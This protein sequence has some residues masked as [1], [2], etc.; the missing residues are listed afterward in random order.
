MSWRAALSWAPQT[1]FEAAKSSQRHQPRP[2]D[3]AC[4]SS[5]G[6]ILAFRMCGFFSGQDRQSI[7]SRDRYN[8][9]EICQNLPFGPLTVQS[10]GF[11]VQ[12]PGSAAGER[13]WKLFGSKATKACEN[14]WTLFRLKSF[15]FVFAN[16]T[17]WRC[18]KV[19]RFELDFVVD[20]SEAEQEEPWTCMLTSNTPQVH[21]SK[22]PCR[23]W[24]IWSL[25]MPVL[26]CGGGSHARQR[27]Q[28]SIKSRL[29]EAEKDLSL[30]TMKCEDIRRQW[31]TVPNWFAPGRRSVA[32]MS[33][34]DARRMQRTTCTLRVGALEAL[35]H[36]DNKT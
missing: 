7:R 28:R 20:L 5:A 22:A 30:A 25:G 26:R 4:C 36:K 32:D 8:L 17:K 31:D 6:G 35:D 12:G 29:L 18:L 3:R 24:A 33:V 23:P 13:Q 2:F 15:H 11:C 34:Q 10:E 14:L 19:M 9:A 27:S 1:T 21:S 16:L